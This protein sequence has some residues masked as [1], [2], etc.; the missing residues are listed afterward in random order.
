VGKTSF[1]Q[2]P[3]S[4]FLPSDGALGKE[5]GERRWG[6]KAYDQIYFASIANETRINVHFFSKVI[7]GSQVVSI[8]FGAVPPL[9]VSMMWSGECC[10]G[11]FYFGILGA[12]SEPE[13]SLQ[14]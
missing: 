7:L 10:G 13:D 1:A 4:I 5:K 2:L 8:F 3:A 6:H 9:D 11:Y 12:I 14:N